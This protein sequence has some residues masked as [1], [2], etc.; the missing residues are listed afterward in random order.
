MKTYLNKKGMEI[1][2][3]VFWII[4]LVM[5]IAVIMWYVFLSNQAGNLIDNFFGGL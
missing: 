5:L 3:L 2:V 4:A 1:W